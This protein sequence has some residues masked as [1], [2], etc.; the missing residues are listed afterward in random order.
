MKNVNHLELFGCE[1]ANLFNQAV[2]CGIR[3]LVYAFT[4]LNIAL[5]DQNNQLKHKKT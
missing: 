3:L 5:C 1:L 4:H 2:R